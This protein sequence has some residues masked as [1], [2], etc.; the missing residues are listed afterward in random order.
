MRKIVTIGLS[1]LLILLFGTIYISAQST[2]EVA[3]EFS[4]PIDFGV[5]I[6]SIATL[7]TA[8]GIENGQHVMYTTA[9]GDPAIFNV[10]D[11][12]ENELLRSIPLPGAGNSWAHT[13][14]PDGNVY[15]A[16]TDKMFRYSADTHEITELGI[17][18]S[19]ESSIWSLTSDEHGNIYGGTF[20]NGKVF[21]FDP[22]SNEFTDYGS[23]DPEQQYVRSIAYKDGIVYAGIGSTGHIIKLDVETG[24]TSEVTIRKIPEIEHPETVYGL[25]VRG[26][27]LFAYLN[28]ES[29]PLI[30]YDLKQ[31]EWL[32]DVYFNYGGLHISPIHENKVS[33]IQGGKMMLFDLDSRQVEET[34]TS[35][36][37]SLRNSAWIP[38][39]ND[40]ELPGHSLVTI[41]YGGNVTIL[42]PESNVVRTNEPI[43]D[44]QPIDLHS[45]EKGPDGSLY[46]TGYMGVN[47]AIYNPETNEFK[48]I[49]IGQSESIGSYRDTVYFGVYPD[50][51]IYAMN[52]KED[53][54]PELL[55][56]VGDDQD[57]PYVQTAGDDKLFFGTIPDYGHLGGTLS[58]YDLETDTYDTHRH[59]I[60]NQSIVGLAYKDG[61]I[62]GSTTVNGG[63][64][65]DPTETE[66]KMFIWDVE[67]STKIDEITPDIPGLEKAPI[68]I[69]GLTFG[70]D[71]LLWGAAEGTIF[72]MDPESL[73]IV[74]SKTIYSDVVGYGNWRPIHIREGND[75]LLYTDLYGQLT[76]INPETM[77][78]QEVGQ[79]T[80]LMTLDNE[81]DIYYAE[82]NR[83]KK[84]EVTGDII[85][86]SLKEVT[87]FEVA[88]GTELADLDLPSTVEAILNNGETR[89]ITVD[90]DDGKPNYDEFKSG[91]NTFTGILDLPNDVTNPEGL[92]VKIKVTVGH[93]Y[94]VSV[95]SL[96][97][98]DVDY[99]TELRDVSL[100]TRVEATLVNDQKAFMSIEWDDG[101]PEYEKNEPGTYEFA[102]SLQ[103]EDGIELG[104]NEFITLAV[105]VQPKEESQ[106]SSDPEKPTD[107][108]NTKVDSVVGDNI[109]DRASG[110]S[111]HEEGGKLPKTATPYYTITLVGILLVLF[112]AILFGWLKVRNRKLNKRI[113]YKPYKCHR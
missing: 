50:A 43:V 31:E 35:F 20:P 9:T 64:G 100:P 70:P 76:V 80:E 108:D 105:T 104:D 103:T 67:S 42:N 11:I 72:A 21:K 60:E 90:W 75:G 16:G 48:T 33:F 36:G 92:D 59:V 78:H 58:V 96:A 5:P 95:A 32:D 89:D 46:M 34:G 66:A 44:G 77:D 63:L 3:K 87:D 24:E 79:S 29:N 17:A 28:N 38:F 37:T 91:E 109:S 97:D 52:L 68:M 71:D 98:I 26:D 13:T 22:N 110:E 41:Q 99:G 84:I 4:E 73:D 88:N 74:K 47:G 45:L 56:K 10:I 57:R 51:Q 1:F 54:E 53:E 25:D 69:S 102:G 40:E 39:E 8:Y 62:Y 55:F 27:L 14:D 112:G 106:A 94:I 30:I 18:V 7:D 86:E 6:E 101:T 2:N 85:I 15:I 93:P 49:P 65:I 23:M 83:L 113:F 107:Q 19:S 82:K 12:K 81:G 61:K 111:H